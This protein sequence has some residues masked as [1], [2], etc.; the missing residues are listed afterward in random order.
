MTLDPEKLRSLTQLCL[1][2]A[3]H[4]GER[5]VTVYHGDFEIMQKSDETPLTTAD[6]EANRIIT[7]GLE[8][9]DFSVPILSEE[10]AVV[11]FNERTGWDSYWLVDPLDGTREFIAR[12]GEFSVNIALIQN[13]KPILGVVYAPI[14]KVAY[15]AA[16]GQ[17]AWKQ[18]DDAQPQPIHVRKSPREAVIV[19]RSRSPVTGPLMKRFLEKLGAHE[20]V[21][22]GSALKSCLVAEGAADVYPKLG[23]TSEWDTGAA[24]CVVEEAGGRIT[25]LKM[26]DLRYNTRESLIN[27][28]FL[29]FGSDERQWN[30]YVPS[31]LSHYPT[32]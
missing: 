23:P 11:S 31:G 12:N 21:P 32:C 17:G 16:R 20:E 7:D 14:L 30:D 4:A 2:I 29:V 25:D 19:A 10:S 13:G 1:H 26:C 9:L 6:L 24:Q 28:H 22:M 5:I 15:F 27:P 3:R 8:A 18:V